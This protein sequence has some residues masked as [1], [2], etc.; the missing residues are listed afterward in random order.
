MT[1]VHE[2]GQRKK[3]EVHGMLQNDSTIG[4]VKHEVLMQVAKHAYAG[5]LKDVE[6]QLPYE[7]IP[8]PQANYRCCVYRER[9]IIRQRIRMAQ[10]M[11]P[12]LGSNNKNTVQVITS[13]CEGCPITRF[14]V[15][16]NCQKCMGRK[17]QQACNFQAITMLRDRA[18]IDPSKCKE[19]GRCAQACPYNAIADLIRPCKRACPVDAITMDENNIVVINEEKCIRCGHCIKDCPFGAIG[20]RSSMVNVINDI[21]AGK[22]VYAMLAP[23]GEG[24]FGANVTM[25][26]L[27]KACEELGFTQ[28]LEVAMGGDLVAD[29]EA[30]EWAEAYAEGRKMTTSCCPAFVNMMR[31]HFPEVYKENMSSTVSPMAAMAR[32]VRAMDPEA[33]TVF[34][35]PCI[36]KKSE[37]CNERGMDNADYAMTFEELAA[38]FDAKGIIPQPEEEYEQGASIYGKRFANAGGVTKAVLQSFKEKNVDAANIKVKECSGA[39]ECKKALMLL[40]AGRLPEDF[41]EGM[42]CEGGCVNGPGSIKPGMESRRD[43]EGLLS[44]TDDRTIGESIQT[45]TSEYTFGM[46]RPEK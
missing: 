32:W 14:I 27:A 11:S 10:G 3:K 26:S 37:I 15:T 29:A 38:M 34:V 25:R 24:Q 43:R 1:L 40:K 2:E 6:E 42:C 31:K 7:M 22:H 17:C 45:V 18:Y 20:D 9:E 30:D 16:D 13:A 39:A 33:V 36:A 12:V 8:G 35:G 44:K 19:C 21:A 5:D 46:H 23:A 41:I 4:N 28:T